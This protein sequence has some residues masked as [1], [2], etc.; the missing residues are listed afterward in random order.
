MQIPNRRVY[1]MME[2]LEGIA[3]DPGASEVTQKHAEEMLTYLQT[4]F[5][6]KPTY[7]RNKATLTA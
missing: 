3:H 4:N 6:S 7:V 1:K 2:M 5:K